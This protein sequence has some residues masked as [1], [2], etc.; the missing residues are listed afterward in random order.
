M[1]DSKNKFSVKFRGV[2]GSYPTPDLS[3]MKYGGNTACV[4]VNVNN[5]LIFLDAGTGIINAGNDMLK[6]YISSSHNEDM[7]ATVLLSHLHQ[8]HIQGIPFFKPVFVRSSLINLVS[9]VEYGKQL[10]ETISELLFDETFPL[11]LADISADIN[12]FNINDNYILVFQEDA[13]VPEIIKV[14][15]DD[16]YLPQDGEV[17]ISCLKLNCHPK[18]GVM[19]YKIAY[20]DKSIVYATDKE[21]YVGGDRKLSMFARNTD[22]LIHDAQYTTDEYLSAYVSKQGYGHSTFD[23]ALEAYSQSHAKSLAFFHL[24]PNYTDEMLIEIEN[25]Y[26]KTCNNVFIPKEGQEITIL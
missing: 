17:V 22:L 3:F 13:D 6:D 12:F 8:D 10:D 26:T 5:H 1:Q 23:M 21:G 7:T 19:V 2:R 16:D 24:D 11:D 9:N 18:R 20:Q 15:T 25:H 14:D 4:E